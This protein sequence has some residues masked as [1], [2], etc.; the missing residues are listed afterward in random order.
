VLTGSESLPTDERQTWSVKIAND[1]PTV[2]TPTDGDVYELALLYPFTVGDEFVF[3]TKGESIA[4]EKAKAEFSSPYVVP[5]PYVGAA[6]FEPGLFATSGRGDRR[7]EFRGLPQNCTVRIYTVRG[8]LVRTLVHDG[9]TNGSVPWDLRTK[10]NLDAAPGLYVFHVD[11]GTVGN[12]VG[13]F[14]IIK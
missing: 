13:K 7:M 9:S 2:T 12:F 10:D 4:S 1:G 8:D 11:A 3:S 6:S 14:A 5:N